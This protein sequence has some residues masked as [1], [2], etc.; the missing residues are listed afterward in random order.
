MLDW[1]E[2]EAPQGHVLTLSPDAFAEWR[3]FQDHI[4]T[5]MRPGGACEHATD[6]A[7]KAAGAAARL[8]GVLHAADHAGGAPWLIP[9]PAQ[10]MR[11]ACALTG[12]FARHSLAAFGLMDAAPE[13]RAARKLWA[14]IERKARAAF[15]PRDAWQG[16]NNGAAFPRMADVNAALGVLEER[17]YVRVLAEPG[18]GTG[19]RPSSPMVIVRPDL[20][21]AWR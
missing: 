5:L 2:A 14:W 1:P 16:L 8:A 15:T 19:G 13:L 4:E 12:V 18:G 20:A 6:W 11:R 21:A 3:T 17:G 9:I 10:T 7:G